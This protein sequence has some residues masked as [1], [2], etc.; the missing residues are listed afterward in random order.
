MCKYKVSVIV[1]VYNTE[2]YLNECIDSILNQS[3]QELQLIL[4]DDGSTDNSSNI[5]DEYKAVDERVIVIHKKNEGPSVARNIGR[6]YVNSEYIYFMDSDDTID[7]DFL[8]NAYKKAKSENLDITI[9]A[10]NNL[11]SLKYLKPQ[12]LVGFGVAVGFYNYNFLSK[13]NNILFNSDLS[14]YEDV[15]FSLQ[16]LSLTDKVG[17]ENNIKYNYRKT[18]NSLS[19]A[20]FN[21][22]KKYKNNILKLL[23]AQEIFISKYGQIIN[24]NNN[25]SKLIAQIFMFNTLFREFSIFQKYDILKQCFKFMCRNNILGIQFKWTEYHILYT[26][27]YFMFNFSFFLYRFYNHNKIV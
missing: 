17:I 4:V 8:L 2:R 5:C 14:L 12:Q 1:P 6:Q 21:E 19:N 9:V 25:T 7:K 27:I 20:S 16:L 13:Y 15:L 26:L 24:L 18:D 10:T 11:K 22:F 3:L 23:E